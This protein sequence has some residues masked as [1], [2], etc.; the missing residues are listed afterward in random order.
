MPISCA[1]GSSPSPTRTTA[2][3]SSSPATTRSCGGTAT[4]SALTIHRELGA[5]NGATPLP[6]GG[7]LVSEI[8]GS[9]VDDFG[10]TGTLR[11]AVRAPVSYPS[12]PQLLGPNRILLADYA[13]P[14]HA[15]IM[16]SAGR[17]LWRYGPRSGPG[18][19]DHPSLAIRIAPGLVA[20][21]DDYRD[22]VVIVS[23]RTHRIVW[24]YGHTDVPGSR[25]GYLNTPDGMDLL[26]TA[27]ASARPVLRALLSHVR[28]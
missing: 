5:V 6:D 9:W 3:C 27:A 14:G 16:T 2:G 20:I 26:P 21:N 1:V 8:N 24:Q 4:A 25:H 17:V 13:R 19:L 15:L 11:W 23:I 10:P 18:E 22:R 28:R 12:D 7:I